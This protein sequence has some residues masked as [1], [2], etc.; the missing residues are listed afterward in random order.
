MT[1]TSGATCKEGWVYTVR[2]G[3][4]VKLGR[5]KNVQRRLRDYWTIAAAEMNIIAVRR[6][7]DMIQ[8]ERALKSW[9]AAY[10]VPFTRE[11][12]LITDEMASSALGAL[13]E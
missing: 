12:F 5:T 3:H 8:A 2:V 13:G 11:L 1:K 6:V 7:A 4:T 9:F 10:R